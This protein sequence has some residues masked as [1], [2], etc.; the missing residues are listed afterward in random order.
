MEP[1]SPNGAEVGGAFSQVRNA[2]KTYQHD[3][4][5][6]GVLVIDNWRMLHG[7]GIDNQTAP[8]RLLLRAMVR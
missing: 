5:R 8:G 2:D 6:G 1:L 4:L 7:R 3:W